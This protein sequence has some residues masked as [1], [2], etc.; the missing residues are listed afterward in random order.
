[1]FSIDSVRGTIGN[2]VTQFL[3]RIETAA[4]ALAA[5]QPSPVDGSK[6]GNNPA[7]QIIE[8]AGHAIY[9]TSALVAAESL[10]TCARLIERM[11]ERAQLD[12]RAAARHS[13]RARKITELV[14]V[15]AKEMRTMLS[16]ELDHCGE[17][18]QWLA[19]AWR[20]RASELLDATLE[21]EPES[22][23]PAES[24]VSAVRGSVARDLTSEARGDESPSERF[25]SA[26]DAVVEISV[27]EFD[28]EAFEIEEIDVGAVADDDIMEAAGAAHA[29]VEAVALSDDQ[30]AEESFAF[31]AEQAPMDGIQAELLEIFRDEVRETLGALQENLEALDSDANDL[32]AARG[33]ER[34]YHTLKGAAATV[35]LE[36]VSEVA[37]RLQRRVEGV[38]DEGE[39]VTPELLE[40][41]ASATVDLLHVA[42]LPSLT[43]SV[44]RD[45][46]SSTPSAE[47][48]AAVVWDETTAASPGEL[49]ESLHRAI[50]VPDP[51]LWQEFNL[52]CADLLEVIDARL[53]AL[54][55]SDSPRAE[56]EALLPSY[57]T[58]KGVLLTLD[59]TPTGAVIHRVEDFLGELLDTAPTA[60]PQMSVVATFLLQVQVEVRR[61]LKQAEKGFVEVALPRVEAHLA[62]VFFGI[63]GGGDSAH[64]DLD[65][66]R[67]SRRHGVVGGEPQDFPGSSREEAVAR[68]FVRVSTERLDQLMNLA[69]E[70]VVSRSRLMSRVQGLRVVQLDLRRGSRRLIETVDQFCEEHEFV[71]LDGGA[72]SSPATAMFARA[73]GVEQT[74]R[75]AAGEPERMGAGVAGW[76]GFSELEMDRYEDLQVLARS[77]TELTSDLDGVYSELA[78]GLGVLTEDSDAF[79]S[80]VSGIQSEITRARM[81]P[82]EVLF[83]SLRLPI[84]D[85]AMREGKDIR[86]TT[87]GESVRLD[88]TIADALFQPM[89]HLVRNAVAHGFEK[90]QEVEGKPRIGSID[91][92]VR[93]ELGQ[94]VI[95]VR[96]DGTGLNLE[97]LR[98]RGIAMGLIRDDVSIDD[99]R[100]KDLVF[101]PGLSTSRSVGD[102]AGRGLGCDIVKRAV[103]RMNGSIHVESESG[104]GTAFVL[105]L[106]LT[107][108]ITRA[109]LVRDGNHSFAVPLYF[110]ERIL[111]VAEQEIVESAGIRRLR[112]DGAFHPVHALGGI[113][114]S[115]SPANPAR[116]AI[117]VIRSG[118]ERVM[119]QVDAIVGQ[120]EIVV[121]SLG[122]ILSGHPLF[123]GVTIRGSGE[124]ALILD[125]PGLLA[126]RHTAHAEGGQQVPSVPKDAAPSKRTEPR[127]RI[128]PNER[129]A[130]GPSRLRVIFVDDS[131]AVRKVAET[132]LKSLGVD[133]T[134]A[135][136]GVDALAKMRERTFDLVFT[137]LE[138]PRMHG[139]ELIR[140]LR[141]RAVYQNLP[142]VV[143]TSRSGQKH[144][145]EARALGATEYLTKP[146][147]ART[148]EAALKKWGRHVGFDA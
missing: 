22:N 31:D 30:V 79:G 110:A 10:A 91:L 7:F 24:A 93:E 129:R 127:S 122:A 74:R 29:E 128:V 146:F 131:L 115:P 58:L 64:G 80:I 123:A 76:G 108:A 89:L 26:K 39:L 62:R 73:D 54:E 145:E 130:E 135:V 106:P 6:N 85:A 90:S 57:H 103:E 44:R 134:L 120:E 25:D 121:K 77:L 87:H 71:R 112:L 53:L 107:L 124:M 50:A 141:F 104:K 126:A 52:E 3:E 117:V 92:R 142:I 101:A 37:S 132:A 46:V 66:S 8:E 143:V 36:A 47:A 69:G 140:E 14:R 109:L 35:G 12:L 78:S 38:V 45:A 59:M 94:V 119:L 19:L 27:E 136:D 75:V 2:D 56:M 20:Q 102:V 114:G 97:R 67:R 148:L 60:L 100:V 147:T 51:E 48:P 63:S 98:A 61:N 83:T 95:E 86:I 32:V 23:G 70:L 9:G 96:D 4:A 5:S 33:L 68:N 137:D 18:A 16:L 15:G 43:L 88:K 84:R 118:A 13:E 41:L 138:M 17:E 72:L 113:L 105:T 133:V 144:Q 111:D 65:K 99:Q 82:M 34:I 42:G 125:I 21:P 1:M 81:V 11:A 139:F 40:E 55:S 116:G 49:P 28:I